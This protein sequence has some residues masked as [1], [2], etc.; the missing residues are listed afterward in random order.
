MLQDGR[1]VVLDASGV[2][3][4]GGQCLQVLL[5]AASAWRQDGYSLAFAAPSPAF[6][7]G[8]SLLGFTPMSLLG[9]D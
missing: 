2:Q 9:K 7:D 5:A 6:E 8:L 3:R 4:I 1:S